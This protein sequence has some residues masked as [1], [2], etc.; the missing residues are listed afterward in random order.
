M[1]Y[2]DTGWF[3][4]A[5]TWMLVG[6]VLLN[7]VRAKRAGQVGK[8]LYIRRIAGLNAIDEAVGRATEMG[9][10]VLMVPGLGDYINAISM[11]AL[12]IFSHV[13]RIA[14]RFHNPILLCCYTASVFTVAQ[15]MMRD[16]YQQEGAL[17]NFDPD[18]VRFISDRQFAFAAG[19]SGLL[20]REQAAA[21][22]LM[23]EFYAESLI[24]AETANSI[25]A[26]QVASSTQ[27]TQTPFFIAACDYVLI[28]D[29]FYAASAYLTRQPVL[30]GSLI[31]QDWSKM[32]IGLVVLLGALLGTYQRQITI[33]EEKVEGAWKPL[34][35]SRKMKE[36]DTFMSHLLH[37]QSDPD[38]LKDWST[39]RD[40][41]KPE[42]LPKAPEE[43]PN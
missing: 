21:T 13:T 31:G 15:E 8:E 40:K 22:F 14:A 16:V 30:V 9:R 41:Y 12:Q 25:G 18:S 37:P 1:Q 19:V 42:D 28:G 39:A 4:V 33:T 7:I 34:A 20:M 26:I 29:E 32:T 6:F 11:Q 5:F 17:D 2:L 38:K 43:G 36:S 27:N 35:E 3:A 24:L 10:P 23:G